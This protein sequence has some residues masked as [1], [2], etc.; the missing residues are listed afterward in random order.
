MYNMNLRQTMNEWSGSAYDV[1]GRNH[2]RN[3]HIRGKK[4]LRQ[5]ANSLGILNADIS[6]C[7]AG[8]AVAGEVILHSDNLYVCV[9]KDFAYFRI[10][11]NRE[12][13]SGGQN[14]N[15]D[16]MMLTIP[17]SLSVYIRTILNHI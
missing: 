1:A 14:Y 11:A 4:H 7:H 12:D 9:S 17:E 16:P 2:K 5:L 13:Y 6:S 15:F 10:C 3:F 8:M